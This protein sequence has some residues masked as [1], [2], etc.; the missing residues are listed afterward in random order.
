M[1]FMSLSKWTVC[2]HFC[3]TFFL[4]QGFTAT[5]PQTWST[6]WWRS[7][8]L[9]CRWC[10][11][12]CEPSWMSGVKRRRT[13]TVCGVSSA[14]RTMPSGCRAR[15][16]RSDRSTDDRWGP[17]RCWTRL[18]RQLRRSVYLVTVIFTH[19]ISHEG[20]A[21]GSARLSIRL[22]LF[23]SVSSTFEL[24]FLWVCGSF[25]LCGLGSSLPWTPALR[26]FESVHYGGVCWS[27]P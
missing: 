21:I 23:C 25:F 27:Q 26:P 14:T 5:T 22:F 17:R 18:I 11:G 16:P 24:E 12:G 9:R 13:T 3:R 19:S 20:K 6:V 10:C 15:R 7:R 1:P 4:H 8:A 2:V